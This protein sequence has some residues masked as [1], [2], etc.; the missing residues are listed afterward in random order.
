VLRH[1]AEG[2]MAHVYEG[3]N[4]D[5]IRGAIK[6]LHT[7]LLSK[8]ELAFRFRREGEIVESI[9]SPHVP[10]VLARGKD[11]RGRPFM[12]FEFVE[13]LELTKILD[14]HVRLPPAV[15]LEITLQMCEALRV[16]HLAGIV[17]RDMKPDNVI[18]VGP[19]DAPLVKV[20]D[21]SVSKDEDLALTQQGHV[22][23]TPCYMA[24]EQA[25]GEPITPLADIYSVGAILYDM[26]T[27]RP[28]YEPDEPGRVLSA[29][30]SKEPPRAIDLN[31]AIPPALATI[32]DTAMARSPKKRFPF[33]ES[34]IEALRAASASITQRD[35]SETLPPPEPTFTSS[36]TAEAQ[37]VAFEPVADSVSRPRRAPSP[38]VSMA[39]V[40]VAAL[41]LLLVAAAVIFGA[42]R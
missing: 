2:G 22:M 20:L 10:Q 16:A 12:V 30:L 42:R 28:P 11:E 37:P 32:V 31:P 33:I 41:I 3:H 19:L 9:K 7:H 8:P 38:N 35:T 34:M 5:G 6:V 36:P 21:F 39:I 1:I 24:I 14:E 17:H 4:A 27:G 26:L 13:G 18:I 29:L 25:L 40:L 15:A 23:G